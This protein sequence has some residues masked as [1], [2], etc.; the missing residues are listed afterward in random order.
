MDYAFRLDPAFR[1]REL[2]LAPSGEVDARLISTASILNTASSIKRRLSTLCGPN[3][4]GR[5][6][7]IGISLEK[8]PLFVA[9]AVG[10]IQSGNA[11]IAL[12]PD[13][14]DYSRRQCERFGVTHVIENTSSGNR[15]RIVPFSA[16]SGG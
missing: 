13:A 14:H 8:S 15:V 6:M 5:G 10:V 7:M 4:H 11:F 2:F 3:I 16:T 9:A 12:D 1:I